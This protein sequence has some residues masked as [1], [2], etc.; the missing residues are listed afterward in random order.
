MKLYD[1]YNVVDNKTV[2]QHEKYYYAFK[3]QKET[4]GRLV[5]TN[6]GYFIDGQHVD[7][8]AVETWHSINKT[9]I[10]KQIK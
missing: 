5:K 6:R 8:K 7:S 2:R 9:P 1:L 4:P 10:Q 3:K